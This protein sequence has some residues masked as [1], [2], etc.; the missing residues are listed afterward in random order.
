[1]SM[2]Y[3]KLGFGESDGDLALLYERVFKNESYLFSA[4]FGLGLLYRSYGAVTDGPTNEFFE[5]MGVAWSVQ[6]AS[7]KS[8]TAG[9][10]VTGFGEFAGSRS[11]GGFALV[12]Q[13]GQLK[14]EPV[15]AMIP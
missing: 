4:G 15:G 5:R 1:M 13:F 12:F 2:R 8:A 9:I 6:A 14:R 3:T 11:F 10:G 7:R